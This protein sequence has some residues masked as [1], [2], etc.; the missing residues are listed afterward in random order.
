[1]PFLL[2]EAVKNKRAILFLGAGASKECQNEQG[3]TPPNADQLRDILSQKFFGKLMPRRNVMSVAEMAINTGAGANLVFDEVNNSFSGFHTSETHRLVS[4]FNWRAI[5]TTNYDLFLEEAYS[6]TKRRKQVLIP[7]VKDDE[8]VDT[9]MG[10]VSFPLQYL[11]LHGCL[12]HRLDKDIP[13]ILSWEQ[14][15]NYSKN[16][17]RLF[18]RLIDL[19]HECPVIFVGYGLADS[20]IREIIYKL[21]AQ[22]RPRWYLIDPSAEEE[23]INFWSSKN[24]DVIPCTFSE[25]MK[26]LDESIP[27]LLRFIVP[28]DESVNFPLRNFYISP[29]HES[30]DLRRSL[31]RDVTLVHAAMSAFE[32]T[33]EQFYSGY[34]TGWGAIIN[35]FDVKRKASEEVLFKALLENESPN[36]PVFFL[37]RGPAGSGKTIALKRAAFDAATANQALVL[38]L[39]EGGQLRPDVFQEIYDLCQQP[40]YL[41]VDEVALH[42]EKLI[43]LLKAMKSRHIP[44]VI[45]G[46]EREADWTTYCNSLEEI[47]P[48]QFLRVGMLSRPEVE[49]LLDL[50]E[51][52]NCLGELKE[53]NRNERIDAFMSE[54]QAD[55][56]LLVALHILTKGLPFEKIVLNEY[57][58]VNPDEAQRLYLDI[59]TMHQF[60]VPVRAGTISRISGISFRDYEQRF[61]LPLKGMV[62]VGQD[63]YTG[64]YT[65]K[66]RHARI[67]ALLFRQVCSDDQT[68]S[69]Q[70]TRIVKALDAG[71]SSDSRT[72]GEI[73]KGRN[74]SK[75]FTAS[76]EVRKIYDAAVIAAPMQ[77]YLYQQWAIFES[78]HPSGD[79]SSAERLAETAASMEPGNTTFIHTQAEVARKRANIE[80]SPVLK[81]QQRRL[82]R[83][84]LAKLPK[85]N[86]FTIST[87]CKLLIDELSEMSATLPDDPTDSQ[88]RAF[89][90]KFRDA[91]LSISRAQ[92]M[93]PDDAEMFEIEARLWR[94]LQNKDKALTAL[95][96]AWKKGPRGSGTALRISR[97]YS[98][99]GRSD[100][101]LLVLKEALSR[102]PEDKGA[103]FAMAQHLLK[104]ETW[105][106]EL[107]INHLK[108]S[109]EQGDHNFEPRYILAQFYFSV[110]RLDDAVSTFKYV[111]KQAPSQFRR[112]SPRKDNVIT[113]RLGEFRGHI[114]SILERF[115]FI[116]SG[117]YPERIYAPRS[118]FDEAI[119]D[120]I[121]L[122]QSVS[123]RLRF[124]RVGPVAVNIT[125]NT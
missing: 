66:T 43:P 63:P 46:A 64:D 84:F 20:H 53:K 17:T 30:T 95:E 120:D 48:P 68:K 13:L 82:T 56:Q 99:L 58:S 27:K 21:D 50:L 80:N 16:R 77:A 91:D 97:I 109:F 110:G 67:A 24:F 89:D 4:E 116:R 42:T 71:Y 114:E 1:M 34:D 29:T 106:E 121:E 117:S 12:N 69:D 73:C 9:R 90:E 76:S 23:D 88:E 22:N 103:H 31:E 41:F 62:T 35:R 40:I 28:S 101:E 3:N 74:L 112:F 86:R 6:D 52:H 111:D 60:C 32:Q 33:A 14:Y 85:E 2:Q 72:L 87:R 125:L 8:P 54:E 94:E 115:S 18:N 92:Q 78:T 57:E 83:T 11:K 79:I 51:R 19:S 15:S 123:F 124:N 38:W 47:L 70:F 7:F 96:R 113:E 119:V 44:L 49:G 36:D 5:A 39:K 98:D 104:N 10:S 105:D 65:Y 55:R 118:E 102:E 93:F 25:F 26:T 75:Q 122:S 59:A 37:L 100:D 107:I 61:F 45:I 108:E 81:D